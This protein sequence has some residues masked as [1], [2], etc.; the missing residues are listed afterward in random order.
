MGGSRQHARVRFRGAAVLGR[1]D[2]RRET[3]ERRQAAE[4]PLLGLL[5]VE[6]LGVAGHERRDDRMLRLPCLQKGVARL[7]AASRASGRL[8]KKLERALGRARIG[9]GETDVGVDHA[10][11]GQK[12][13]VMPLGDQLR[14]D[15]EVE[16]A[17]RRRIEL[18]AQ[19]SIPPGVSDDRTNVRMSGKRIPPPRPGARLPARRR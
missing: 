18:T 6:P 3:A 16:G 10:D 12:R 17:A 14:A 1:N 13:K 8:T 9:V 4:S 2:D 11:K 15:D 19:S 7:V 5:R